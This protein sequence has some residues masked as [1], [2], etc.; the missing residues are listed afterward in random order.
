MELL[1]SRVRLAVCG[2]FAEEAAVAEAETAEEVSIEQG[3]VLA[4]EEVEMDAGARARNRAEDSFAGFTTHRSCAPAFTHAEQGLHAIKTEEQAEGR[5]A[6]KY[7][8]I[9]KCGRER[10]I[11]RTSVNKALTFFRRTGRACAG[12]RRTRVTL[13][14]K[15]S[16][17][18]YEHVQQ[19]PTSLTA[20]IAQSGRVLVCHENS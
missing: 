8:I 7:T 19:E 4:V 6:H 16:R 2:S 1:L 20:A 13:S 11:F 5:R 18:V 10:S 3:P 14:A 9:V 15:Q 17:Q 12:T